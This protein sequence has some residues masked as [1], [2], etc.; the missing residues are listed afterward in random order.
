M[1][2]G[3]CQSHYNRNYKHGHPLAGADSTSHTKP[4]SV[5]GCDRTDRL[6]KT[7]C[8]THY[9]RFVKN[10]TPGPPVG[11]YDE[12]QAI[13]RFWGYVDMSLG[14]DG[15]WPWVGRTRGRGPSKKLRYG[16]FCFKTKTR[17]AHRLAYEFHNGVTLTPAEPIHHI[18]GN[19]VCQNPKHLQVVTMAENTAEMLERRFYQQRIAELEA[20]VA[21]CT[22]KQNQE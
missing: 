13:K 17:S 6:R 10:G 9:E 22:C 8:S 7:F 14:E 12:E 1:S 20:A 21:A 18:C 16:E 15:C 3:W 5:V 2:K 19:S 4:C 11:V